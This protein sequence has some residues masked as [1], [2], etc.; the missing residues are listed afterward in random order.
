MI[1]KHAS[2]GLHFLT[3][4]LRQLA[5]AY[6]QVAVPPGPRRVKDYVA[7]DEAETQSPSQ[8]YHGQC[9]AILPQS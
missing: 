9:Q 1:S 5:S 7:E 8:I 6:Y 3:V 4:Q 2:R